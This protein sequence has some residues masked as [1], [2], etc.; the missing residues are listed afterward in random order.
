M[1]IL[2]RTWTTCRKALAHV[3]IF[4]FPVICDIQGAL[5]SFFLLDT[6]RHIGRKLDF[7][8]LVG[9]ISK[10]FNTKISGGDQPSA[11]AT[12]GPSAF[13]SSFVES[14]GALRNVTVE[15]QR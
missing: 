4:L 2:G 1:L 15:R 10:N 6:V 11:G 9:V 7:N 8:V 3:V 12:F 14:D 5:G 13:E